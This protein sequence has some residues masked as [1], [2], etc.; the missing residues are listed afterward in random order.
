VLDQGYMSLGTVFQLPY[1]D[2]WRSILGLSSSLTDVV[3]LTLVVIVLYYNFC[4]HSNGSF[5]RNVL[6]CNLILLNLIFIVFLLTFVLNFPDFYYIYN[7][8]WLAF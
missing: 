7:N 1:N 3:L 4:I 6:D 8:N 2:V 5:T